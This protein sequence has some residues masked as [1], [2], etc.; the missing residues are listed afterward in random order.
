MECVWDTSR[1]EV[2]VSYF[3]CVARD[4]HSNIPQERPIDR[5]RPSMVTSISRW[6]R[7]DSLASNTVKVQ[8][9]HQ[10]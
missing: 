2:R 3:Q 7:I 8:Q 9:P 6:T 4:T 5:S 10:Y 1:S